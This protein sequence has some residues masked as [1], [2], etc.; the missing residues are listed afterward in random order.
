MLLAEALASR[1]SALKKIGDLEARIA[2]SAVSYEDEK[3]DDK[4][5]DLLGEFY[6]LSEDFESLSTRINRTNNDI[7]LHFDGRELSMMEAVALRESLLLRQRGLRRIADS[8]E[9]AQGRGRYSY[10]GRRTKDELKQTVHLAPT[11]VRK[12]ADKLSERIER[13]NVAMQSVN[14]TTEVIEA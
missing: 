12:D 4:V 1:K 5:A 6:G 7:T 9:Q 11:T 2:A 14:W 13:L 8:I 3:P 10:G